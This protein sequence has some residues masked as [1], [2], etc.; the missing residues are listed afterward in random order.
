MAEAMK[1]VRELKECRNFRVTI[2]EKKADY[3][4]LSERNGNRNRLIV[5]DLQGTVVTVIVKKNVKD[6]L[7][8]ICKKM[9]QTTRR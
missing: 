5:F 4:F 9:A 7:K 8:D 2:D 1:H 6:S 3:V